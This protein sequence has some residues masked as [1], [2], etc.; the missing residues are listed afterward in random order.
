MDNQYIESS[1]T[2]AV[3]LLLPAL[4]WIHFF[5]SLSFKTALILKLQLMQQ[6]LLHW[7]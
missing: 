5:Q 3:S 4:M 6:W 2:F 1:T 7:C